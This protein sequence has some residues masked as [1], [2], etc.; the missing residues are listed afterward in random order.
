MINNWLRPWRDRAF[1]LLALAI[2]I[3]GFALSSIILLH[4]E[5]EQRF[6]VRTAEMLFPELLKHG[7]LRQRQLH[8]IPNHRYKRPVAWSLQ[9]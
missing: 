7:A 9:A 3:A 2:T 8:S 4:A 5:L 6:A 1:Q